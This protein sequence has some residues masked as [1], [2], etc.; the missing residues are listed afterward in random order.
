MDNDIAH[1]APLW[2]NKS[3]SKILRLNGF[4]LGEVILTNF[5]EPGWPVVIWGGTEKSLKKFWEPI[6]ETEDKEK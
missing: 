4:L 5:D 2:R 1:L 3:S 6:L